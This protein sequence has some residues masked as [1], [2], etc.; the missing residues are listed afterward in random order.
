MYNDEPARGNQKS[1]LRLDMSNWLVN[2]T[3]SENFKSF[4]A[5]VFQLDT[6][7]MI[8]NETIYFLVPT[9]RQH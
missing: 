6:F 2:D 7:T 9:H 3:I 8:M 4:L 5:N 1:T